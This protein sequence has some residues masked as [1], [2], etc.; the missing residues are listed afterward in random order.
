MISI[1]NIPASFHRDARRADPKRAS[2]GLDCRKQIISNKLASK[3]ADK[4]VVVDLAKEE[5]YFDAAGTLAQSLSC[6]G[7]EIKRHGAGSCSTIGTTE[8]RHSATSSI[9]AD[10]RDRF[11][12]NPLLGVVAPSAPRDT[13]VLRNVA[14]PMD[15]TTFQPAAGFAMM[16]MSY[17]IQHVHSALECRP[18]LE[19]Q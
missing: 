17:V 13:T 10:L 18:F 11:R 1:L 4:R 5:V 16:C 8:R 6:S 14:L 15:S 2:G 3:R 12:P 9:A 19:P 7:R